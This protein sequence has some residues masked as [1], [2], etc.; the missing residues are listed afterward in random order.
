MRTTGFGRAAGLLRRAVLEH[1]HAGAQLSALR[2]VTA[3]AALETLRQMPSGTVLEDF[4]EPPTTDEGRRRRRLRTTRRGYEASRAVAAVGVTLWGAG[5]RSAPVTVCANLA[6]G[7]AQKHVVDFHPKAWNYNSHLNAF[8]ALLS[9]VERAGGRHRTGGPAGSPEGG[10][11]A[12]FESA[13][14]AVLQLYYAT[15]YFQSGLAKLRV[16]GPGWA[17]GRTLRASL[18][19]HGN[20][21]GKRLSTLPRP[22]HAATA[23]GALAFELLFPLALLALQDR[24]AVLALASLGFHGAVRATMGISFWHHAVFAL[25]LFVPAENVRRALDAVRRHLPAR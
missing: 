6:F 14:L 9:A 5:V 3:L 1:P 7:L 10:A 20:A 17:D 15:M 2:V 13:A 4:A 8:L 19:E 23:T 22:V 25:P 11:D 16:G 21:V 12:Q 18:A 24:K